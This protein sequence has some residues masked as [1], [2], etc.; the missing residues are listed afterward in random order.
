MRH[1]H[2]L[3][4]V[5]KTRDEDRLCIIATTVVFVAHRVATD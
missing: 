2:D 5:S 1:N 4:T 3:S